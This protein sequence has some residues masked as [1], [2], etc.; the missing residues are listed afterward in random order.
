MSTLVES[1]NSSAAQRA[2]PI[3]MRPDLQAASQYFQG[4]AHWVVKD[5]LALEYYRLRDE[6]YTILSLLDG[7]TSL[8]EL[9]SKFDRRFAPRHISLAQLHGFLGQLYAMGLV[10]ADSSG[11]GEQLLARHDTKVHGRR[12]AALANVLAWRFRGFDPDKLLEPLDAV[13]GWIFRPIGVYPAIALALAAL[14]LITVQFDAFQARLPDFHQFFQARNAIWIAV[15]LMFTKMVHEFGHGLACKHFG[16]ECHEIGVMLLVGTPS[17]Y[18]NVSDSWMLPNKWHRAA[19]GAAGM[20]VELVLASIATFLWWFSEPGLLNFLCLNVMFVSSV[21]TLVFNANPL[22]RYDGY[23]ILSDLVEIPN[24]AE[25]SKTLM[26]QAISQWCLGL[27][28]RQARFLPERHRWLIA[29]YSV[30]SGVYRW[31]VTFSILWFLNKVFEPY[32]LDVLGQILSGFALYGLVVMPLWQMGKFFAV[33]GRIGQV[34]KLRVAMTLAVF[35]AVV[36]GIAL[37]PV[38]NRVF[39]TLVVEPRDAARVWI[40][41]PGTLERVEVAPG[42][43]VTA[44]QSLAEL[45]DPLLKFQIVEWTGKRDR[46]KTVLEGYRRREDDPKIAVQIPS[47]EQA[48]QE[49][50]EQLDER[51]RD[52]K[53]LRLSAPTSGTILPPPA[54]PADTVAGQAARWT[55]TPLDKTNIGA[56]LEA[57]TMFCLVGDPT[58]L[59]AALVIDQRDI[60]FVRPGLEVAIKLDELPGE[61]LT[62][63]IAEVAEVDLDVAPRE[64]ASRSGGELETRTDRAGRD[65]PMSVS[66]QARVAID[67]PARR[68]LPGFRGRAKIQAGSITLGAW[69]WRYLSE[70]FHFK[71]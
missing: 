23:Y 58:Q 61:T 39:T 11:Q 25:I 62:G 70:T 57:G 60:D 9:K 31:V 3:R 69:F 15:T 20:Y 35:A 65:R 47:A 43:Q 59:Q 14:A 48:L 12:M 2:L 4:K 6:E 52:Y 21:S 18:C 44:G 38:P 32:Q 17:L 33:P 50:Q 7:K 19:I 49:I 28:P 63:H 30:A 10:L 26:R 5:P 37:V 40:D 67:D 36:A 34:K 45:A 71:L 27:E 13:A 24:L 8:D 56:Y 51:L 16:G 41:V 22:L 55:G 46:Q 66:Y 53:R 68:I 29:G 42:D 1:L 54:R 64:L